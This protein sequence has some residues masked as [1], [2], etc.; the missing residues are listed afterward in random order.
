MAAFVGTYGSQCSKLLA[1]PLQGKFLH[2]S[3]T[4]YKEN[5]SAVQIA[6]KLSPG[7][8]SLL[9]MFLDQSCP[10]CLSFSLPLSVNSSF[11][12]TAGLSELNTDAFFLCPD[13][14]GL[15]VSPKLCLSNVELQSI[16]PSPP[17]E[18]VGWVFWFHVITKHPQPSL[19]CLYSKELII[20]VPLYII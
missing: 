19:S 5:S 20:Y 11:C 13:N 2:Q 10:W 9:S 3:S 15:Q 4:F 1:G 17:Q 7:C 8:P 18:A 6:E 14:Q 12:A 16:T